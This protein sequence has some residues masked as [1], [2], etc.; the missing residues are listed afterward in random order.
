MN[1]NGSKGVGF[2]FNPEES[3]H[4]FL[5]SISTSSAV[6]VWISEHMSWSHEMWE[7]KIRAVT[8]ETDERLRVILSRDRWERILPAV[9]AEFNAR[10]KEQGEKRGR[11]REKG[12]TPLSRTFGKELVLLA[13][14]IEDADPGRVQAAVT[15]WLGLKPEERWWL[16]TMTNAATGQALAGRNR[17]WRIAVRYA[18]CENPVGVTNAEAR[19]GLIAGLDEKE[20]GVEDNK[21]VTFADLVRE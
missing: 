20:K 6:D 10:L 2:G 9:T 16:Y 15:N 19:V 7:R 4:Y 12:I 11:W 21:Q 18:L 13:W 1:G 17:G 8:K 3:Q 14:A 5:V